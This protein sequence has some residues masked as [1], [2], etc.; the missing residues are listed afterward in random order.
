MI[1]I[2]KENNRCTP[3]WDLNVFVMYQN[4]YT[5]IRLCHFFSTEHVNSKISEINTYC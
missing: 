1:L 5:C 3:N 4:V 2:F